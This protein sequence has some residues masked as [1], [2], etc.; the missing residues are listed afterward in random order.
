M[1]MDDVK[2][3]NGGQVGMRIGD[4]FESIV[5]GAKLIPMYDNDEFLMKSLTRK[6]GNKTQETG[7][8]DGDDYNEAALGPAD[9]Y[10]HYFEWS[11]AHSISFPQFKFDKDHL[12]LGNSLDYCLGISWTTVKKQYQFDKYLEFRGMDYCREAK[13]KRTNQDKDYPEHG[14]NFKIWKQQ[15]TRDDDTCAG[16]IVDAHMNC[17]RYKVMK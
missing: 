12:P 7:K 4:N 8:K 11:S 17:Y 1:V 9:E 16:G 2:Q 10:P 15:K 5:I 14:I 13:N 6:G 3:A